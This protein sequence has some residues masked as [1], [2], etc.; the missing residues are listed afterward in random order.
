[1]EARMID[2]RLLPL[3]RRLLARPARWLAARGV[4]ADNV[5][6]AGF[7]LGLAVVPALAPG[8]PGV[9]LVFLALNRVADGLDGAVAREAG[10]TD[11][12]AFLDI[13]LDFLF[14]AL[15]PLGFA[16]A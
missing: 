4:G 10:P 13:A 2:A 7:A 12:G 6:L 14:Y 5:T 1:M 16:L 15:V 9:A 8:L 11:R 3:Q